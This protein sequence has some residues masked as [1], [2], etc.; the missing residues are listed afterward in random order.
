MSRWRKEAFDR[1]PECRKE[2]QAEKDPYGFFGALGDVLWRAHIAK[3][4]DLIGR[5]Y[6]FAQWCLDAPRGK[7]AADD[8]LS[9]VTVAFFE[10][11]PKHKEV[12][13][14][15]GR[16]FP[17]DFIK[18]MHEVFC[19]IESEEKYLEM[20]ASCEVTEF[21]KNR[22]NQSLQRNASTMSSSTIK[23]AVRHG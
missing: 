21:K 4:E 9:I 20:L 11:V 12:R 10:G 16:W 13:Q 15:I 7:D 14:E 6:G 17:R 5:I 1:L 22:A 3:D 8:L 23:S 2:L 19:Y 18:G